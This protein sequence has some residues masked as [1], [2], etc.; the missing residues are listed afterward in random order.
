[1]IKSLL[2]TVFKISVPNSLAFIL[3]LPFEIHSSAFKRTTLQS[4][5]VTMLSKDELNKCNDEGG[6]P[7]E[8]A[9]Y[10]VKLS[11]GAQI[12]FAIA[13]ILVFLTQLGWG[14]KGRMWSFTFWMTLGLGFEVIGYLGRAYESKNPFSIDAYTIEFTV[15][16]LA[17]TFLAAA[18]SVT[19]KHI[20]LYYDPRWSVFR[21]KLYPWVFVGTDFISIFIQVVGAI[22]S[23]SATTS[24]SNNETLAD[25]GNYAVLGGVIF[26]VINMLCCS[27]L[28]VLYAMRRKSDYRSGKVTRT[29]PQDYAMNGLNAT[30]P[31]GPSVAAGANSCPSQPFPQGYDSE[32]AN[33]SNG[34]PRAATEERRAK[35]FV[36]ALMLAYAL[37][38]IRCTYR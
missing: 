36:W 6:C 22:A 21:P 14:I 30:P 5:L 10:G 4:G 35:I 24:D 32:Q 11:M 25:V 18:L 33:S 26:Q 9:F 16:L 8:G 28:M 1:M 23:A 34:S 20:V 13:F 27:T 7:I 29:T 37:I 12:F 31:L 38:I 3:Q 15:I 17:P 2:Y 19:F